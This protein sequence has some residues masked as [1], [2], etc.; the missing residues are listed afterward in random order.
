M[1]NDLHLVQKY[2]FIF[3][4]GYFSR[5]CT[6]LRV[7]GLRKTVDCKEQMPKEKYRSIFRAKG[8]YCVYYPA[9]VFRNACSFKNWG[10][11]SPSL[12]SVT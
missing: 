1:N 3:I 7:S 2:A 4:N 6:V 5:K 8:S 9:N 12:Y 11:F 10:I